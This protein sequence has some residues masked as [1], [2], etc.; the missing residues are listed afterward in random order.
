MYT[1]F[2]VLINQIFRDLK[3]KPWFK[4]SPPPMRGDTSKI[5]QTKYCTFHTVPEHTTNGCTTW[6]KYLENLVK[7]GKCNQY[8]D[9]LAAQANVDD[10]PPAK[11]I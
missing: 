6:M 10:E 7:E 2:S 3:D 9:R 1:K 8:I 11:M 4:P 5:D